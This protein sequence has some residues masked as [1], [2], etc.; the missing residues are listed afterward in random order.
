M[1]EA[2]LKI[3]FSLALL[4]V[5]LCLVLL[6]LGWRFYRITNPPFACGVVDDTTSYETSLV[7]EEYF[8]GEFIF[9]E[10]CSRC[11][12]ASDKKLCGPGFKDILDRVESEQWLRS[13]IGNSDSVIKAGD[14]Y[15]VD[16]HKKYGNQKFNHYWRFSDADWKSLL[17]YITAKPVYAVTSTQETARH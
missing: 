12:Y 10:N 15:A 6:L 9:K 16:L 7:S 4:I 3:K 14:A 11:H 5:T 8:R 17:E 2:L 13:Y 1:L